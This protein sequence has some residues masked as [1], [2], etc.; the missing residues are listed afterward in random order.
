[1]EGG[2]EMVLREVLQR[3]GWC[4]SLETPR[5]RL[6]TPMLQSSEAKPCPEPAAHQP[7][8]GGG[9]HKFGQKEG[10]NDGAGLAQVA[11]DGRD[12]GDLGFRVRGGGLCKI[13]GVGAAAA[14]DAAGSGASGRE[15]VFNVVGRGYRSVALHRVGAS[16]VGVQHACTCDCSHTPCCMSYVRH[17][18]GARP[19]L[20][21]ES[22]SFR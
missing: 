11:A 21:L 2:G 1:M 12:V 20:A 4:G 22:S 15:A 3:R 18:T 14:G 5:G 17:V 7:G 9:G 13:W 16:A 6:C 8:A 19:R 10:G